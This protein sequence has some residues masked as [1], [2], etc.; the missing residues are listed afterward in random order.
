MATLLLMASCGTQKQFVVSNPSYH[1][2]YPEYEGPAWVKNESKPI[3]IT[4]G[5]ENKHVAVTA[6]HGRYFDNKK[7]E[8]AW[9][10]PYMNGTRED[11]FTSTIVLPYLIPMLENAGANVF[12]TRERDPQEDEA[13]VDGGKEFNIFASWTECPSPGF[14]DRAVTYDDTYHPFSVGT[15]KMAKANKK[16]KCELQFVPHFTRAGKYAVY[17][18]YPKYR[19]QNVPDAKYIVVHGGTTTEFTV[20]QTMG[21]GTWV[22][23]G[24]FFFEAGQPLRN[25][26]SLSNESKYKGYVTADAV[27]FGGGKGRVVRGGTISGESRN[28]EAARYSAQW[29]GAPDRVWNTFKHENDYNDDIRT[30]P[31]MANWVAGGSCFNP[32]ED[33]LNVPLEL[34]L[35]VHSDAGKTNDSTYIGTLGICTT[36]HNGG[37]LG[38]GASRDASKLFATSLEQNIFIDITNKFGQWRTRGTWDKNY[39][40][41]RIP[42]MPSAIIE[43]LSHENP[44]DMQ[45]GHDPEFK[46]TLARSMYKTILR[47]IGSQHGRS[48]VVQ[49]LPPS[50][51]AAFKLGNGKLQVQ[52]LTQTD[53]T[54]PTSNPKGFMLY[55][56]INGGDY[57][58]GQI[59]K[60]NAVA[61]NPQPNATYRFKVTAFNDGGESLPV[62]VVYR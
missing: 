12:S 38:C 50:N 61:L 35:A 54:E 32:K 6:S 19:N 53:R 28:V 47:F 36:N 52:W 2:G 13:I 15:T 23:L 42:E 44:A 22:Y 26:V 14:A 25:Y 18:A 49:P 17:V 62:E 58:N 3:H 45:K 60:G 43:I 59:V 46:F 8:W 5:L 31:S 10:R 4:K 7:G 51:L 21:Q 20:N 37:K 30:R 9:Q 16:K 56:A 11:I 1:K 57:D 48:V 27:R 40:E 33:G 39:G 24:T 41:S 29:Y 55:I 34:S